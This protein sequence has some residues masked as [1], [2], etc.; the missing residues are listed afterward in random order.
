MTGHQLRS[1]NNFRC[2]K[3]GLH[4]PLEQISSFSSARPLAHSQ[5]VFAELPLVRSSVTVSVI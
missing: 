3:L 5:W 4:L 1:G 2:W